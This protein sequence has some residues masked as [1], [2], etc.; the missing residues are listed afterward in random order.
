MNET[1]TPGDHELT[2]VSRVTDLESSGVP[3]QAVPES[4]SSQETSVD[5]AHQSRLS[6]ST[7]HTTGIDSPA[8]TNP[9]STTGS[10]TVTP[11]QLNVDVTPI[12]IDVPAFPIVAEMVETEPSNIESSSYLNLEIFREA[13]VVK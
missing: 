13:L 4:R 7:S 5:C 9:C 12:A 1:V 11:S 8:V 2:V 6:L 3:F 10:E